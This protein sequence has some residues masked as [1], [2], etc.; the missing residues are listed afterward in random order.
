MNNSEL[1]DAYYK[2]ASEGAWN[3]GSSYQR[4]ANII[5]RAPFSYKD[6]F[7]EKGNLREIP[8]QMK[9]IRLGT[10]IILEMIIEGDVDE[11]KK[12]ASEIRLQERARKEERQ[13]NSP[14][15]KNRI[16]SSGQIPQS[17][18]I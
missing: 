15:I 9:G 4:I 7:F 14:S 12:L 16:K 11:A 17:R 18:W 5:K 8:H 2:I 10:A 1:A 13:N 3:N 6:W